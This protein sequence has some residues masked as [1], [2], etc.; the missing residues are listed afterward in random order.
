MTGHPFFPA[1]VPGELLY[2]FLARFGML[3]GVTSPK[4]LMMDL[5]GRAN[6]IATVDLPN[7]IDALSRSLPLTAAKTADLIQRHTL[8]R[9]Y[10]AFQSGEQR[11]AG[12]DAM[13]GSEGSVHFLLGAT[14]FR[15][16]RPTHLQ[17]C[18]NCLDDQD[19]EHGFLIWRVEHQL[20]G[21]I[22]CAHHLRRLRRSK[23]RLGATNRHA[24]IAASRK[25]CPDGC[26]PVSDSIV[27]RSLDL[28]IQM[29]RK[30]KQLIDIERAETTVEV[31]RDGYRARLT[32]IGLVKGTQKVRQKE[33]HAIFTDHYGSLLGQMSGAKPLASSE[34]W[35]NSIVR[36]RKGAHSPVHHLLLEIFLEAIEAK[37]KDQLS[38]RIK[39][40]ASGT[41]T[42]FGEHSDSDD[43][44]WQRI[45]RD[46]SIEIRKHAYRLERSFPPVRVTEASIGR[47]LNGRDWLA[48]RTVKLPISTIAMKQV[49]EN[50]DDFQER[51]I[52]CYVGQCISEGEYDPWVALRRAGL[53]R[54][55]IGR[56]RSEFDNRVGSIPKLAVAA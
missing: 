41:C 16:G 28:A 14:V 56:V 2:S 13:L 38:S 42:W 32:N 40:A 45:D 5:Y 34:T 29:A 8:F 53:R 35:L 49:A 31:L 1:L 51:R 52:R 15:T 12:L 19:H 48:K 44:D 30:S 6:M 43:L 24:Y 47:S 9:Y 27:G 55:F 17:F 37:P 23:V 22:V 33:L 20:P 46:Y 11:E 3:R 36:S 26:D 10:T 39:A 25:V 21:V 18:P 4:S 7:N 50:L 54:E